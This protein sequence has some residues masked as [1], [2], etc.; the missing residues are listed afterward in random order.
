MMYQL[1][2]SCESAH[3]P[4]RLL[5]AIA[6][7]LHTTTLRAQFYPVQAT[8]QLIPPYS[9]YLPDYATPGNEKLR[10]IL[11]QHDL[12][13]AAYQ[14]RL[15]LTVEL[16]GRVIMRTSRRFMPPPITLDPGVPTIIA[17]TDL[18]PYV[19]AGNLEFTGFDRDQYLRTKSLPEGNYRFTFTAYDYRRQDVQVSNVASGY[20]YLAKSEPP[21]INLP[22]CGTQVPLRTPQ[23]VIFS[24]W[25]RN[26]SSPNSFVDTYYELTIYETRPEGRN[27]NDIVLAT[28][29]VFRIET[30]STQYIYGLTD[31][32]LIEGM[33]YVWRVRAVDGSGKDA[34]RNHGYS[35]TCT[36][37]YKGADAIFDIGGVHN[38]R[39]EAQT[40]RRAQVSWDKAAYD[41]YIVSYKKVG[42]GFEWFDRQVKA[43]DIFNGQHSEFKL[44]DLEPNTAYEVRVQPK[45]SGYYGNYS[46]I[47]TFRTKE[48][49][50]RVCGASSAFHLGDV[51]KPN[52]SL[53]KGTIIDV[54]GIEVQLTE[55]LHLGNG[56][57]KGTGRTSIDFFGGAVFAVV[58]ER[59]FV[60]EHRVAGMGRIDFVTE[61]V[62]SMVHDQLIAGERQYHDDVQ[63]QN[64]I[65]WEGTIFY[66]EVFLYDDLEIVDITFADGTL[67]IN[68]PDGTTVT[69]NDIPQIL[70]KSAGK[71]IIIQDS[72]GDQYVVKKEGNQTSVTKVDAGGL[73]PGVNTPI[74]AADI[75]VI[76]KVLREIR[77]Q[78]TALLPEIT[79]RLE[80][81]T[82]AVDVQVEENHRALG[83]N[84]TLIESND[85]IDVM[86]LSAAEPV[87]SSEEE[88]YQQ[89]EV[90]F[91]VVHVALLLSLET[92][93]ENSYRIIAS[94]L[95]VK[96]QSLTNYFAEARNS[97]ISESEQ[98]LV[99]KEALMQKV[100]QVVHE[101]VY[102]K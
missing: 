52:R 82:R 75:D 102:E 35:E 33:Q 20:Y 40:E 67:T 24:W 47:V 68:T 92:R 77:E 26:M 12:T 25:P 99:I 62:A 96:D 6:C 90:W 79:R 31:P 64:R 59:L 44:F 7:C 38:L 23:Q 13:Q 72:S 39:A 60:D 70:I 51:S 3:P 55:V 98:V 14:L 74:A 36:F 81:T 34:F 86:E 84:T 57:Y 2:H 69:N 89:A 28:Q 8:T 45:R 58:F 37:L 85:D 93:H 15:V 80:E 5:I 41:E 53:I 16:E 17:G 88:A 32:L 78:Y 83:A 46:D 71:A 97:N 76:R 66:E 22:A 101:Y 42:H 27:P 4:W 63:H 50:A 19:D 29:P 95:R 30:N 1:F 21:L 10:V 73:T 61:G 100:K 18:S 11:L 9:V 43:T 91:N 54:D 94:S 87:T 49:E 48:H 65:D 56:W